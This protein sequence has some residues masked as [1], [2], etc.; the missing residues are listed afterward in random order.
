MPTQLATSHD[1][2]GGYSLYPSNSNG[3]AYLW[4]GTLAFVAGDGSSAELYTVASPGGASPS[5]ALVK[6]VSINGGSTV[7]TDLFV[8]NN[9]DS[10][11][12]VWFGY[13]E[14]GSVGGAFVVHGK[15]DSGGAWTW[16][17]ATSV[18]GGS[19]SATSVNQVSLVW[20]GTYLIALLRYIG[21]TISL[22]YTST[23]N[24]TG[25]WLA[26]PVQLA[27]TSGTNNR[28][29]GQLVHDATL[30]ATVA[31]YS[32][33]GDKLVSRVLPDSSTPAVANWGAESD[34]GAGTALNFGDFQ[35]A[36]VLW[37]HATGRVHVAYYDASGTGKSIGYVSGTVSV[38]GTS[39]AVT[40]GSP[41]SVGTQ[42]VAND[43]P[44]L[45]VDATGR[46]FV[47]WASGATGAASDIMAAHLDSPYTSA[48]AAVN[49]TNASASH[50]NHPMTPRLAALTLGYVPL[51]YV[52]GTASPFSIEYDN[53][54]L[55]SG[56]T[57]AATLGGT[58]G[59]LLGAGIGRGGATLGGT[60]G[61]LAFPPAGPVL[62]GAGIVGTAST[63]GKTI[64]G[65]TAGGV[66][67]AATQSGFSDPIIGGTS[68]Q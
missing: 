32:L 63:T 39:S 16:D 15:Y 57:G 68:R 41:V 14:N 29:F 21:T 35:G 26:S 24:G 65:A 3:A 2:N 43:S 51:L 49:I 23:K 6:T 66:V 40:W 53:T 10:T 1:G 62:F 33:G 64:G 38:N 60:T 17:A 7:N 28:Y 4:N 45:C 11:S 5:A 55:P 18:L 34:L 47:L 50:N 30:A 25:G 31:V 56:F 13:A 61:G 46:V 59:G 67:V 20:T 44:D 37:D 54:S 9:G 12:D 27:S 58:L 42:A 48:S 19:G 52:S 22:N 8:V 36:A